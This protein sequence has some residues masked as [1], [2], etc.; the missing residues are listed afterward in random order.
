MFMLAVT[1]LASQALAGKK[2]APLRLIRVRWY[3]PLREAWVL[4]APP[5]PG[6]VQSVPALVP[7]ARLPS[8]EFESEIAPHA[9]DI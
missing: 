2:L 6:V 9:S 4:P 7:K 3:M 8:V 5:T 1:L